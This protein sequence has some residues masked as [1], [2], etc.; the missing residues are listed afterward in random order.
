MQCIK[1]VKSYIQLVEDIHIKSVVCL[2][3]KVILNPQSVSYVMAKTKIADKTSLRRSLCQVYG[4]EDRHQQGT[5]THD[6]KLS[7]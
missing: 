5:R 1:V 6:N 4:A 3:S 7:Y 2:A